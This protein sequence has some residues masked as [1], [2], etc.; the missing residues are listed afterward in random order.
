MRFRLCLGL[1]FIRA[2]HIASPC[3]VHFD[4]AVPSATHQQ[5]HRLLST[6]SAMTQR[7]ENSLISRTLSSSAPHFSTL[8]WV[9]WTNSCSHDSREPACS[10]TVCAALKAGRSISLFSFFPSLSIPVHLLRLVACSPCQLPVDPLSTK[11]HCTIASW[12][13]Q[14]A[15]PS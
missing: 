10:S 11:T 13:I 4:C 15:A 8:R 7:T 14:S 3:L 5:T 6:G 9:W 12:K 1:C 2:P